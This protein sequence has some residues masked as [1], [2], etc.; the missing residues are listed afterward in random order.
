MDRLGNVYD[1]HVRERL[2][3]M[4]E[5]K[6]ISCTLTAA[7]RKARTMTWRDVLRLSVTQTEE[8]A[9]GFVLTLDYA[10]IRR[11]DIRKLVE[12]ERECCRWM[13]LELNGDS[14]TTLSITSESHNGK[15]VIKRMLGL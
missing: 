6:P 4:R 14:E 9:N 12:S 5:S 11:E 15:A 10:A 2:A 1:Y 3:E 7:Q 13:D 8:R